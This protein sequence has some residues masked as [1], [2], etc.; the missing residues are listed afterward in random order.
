MGH[1]D[2]QEAIARHRS[3]IDRVLSLILDMTVKDGRLTRNVAHGVNLPRIVKAEQRY[4]THAPVEALAN[5]CGNR[6]S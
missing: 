1:G 2:G 5:E 4:L 6:R 3:Q